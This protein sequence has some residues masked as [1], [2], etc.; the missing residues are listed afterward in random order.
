MMGTLSELRIMYVVML[1][2]QRFCGREDLASHT[3]LNT[4]NY[5]TVKPPS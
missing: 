3:D 2:C 4:R 5:T 1:F